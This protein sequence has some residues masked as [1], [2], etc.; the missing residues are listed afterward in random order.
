MHNAH[1][2]RRVFYLSKEGFQYSV[3]AEIDF[4]VSSSNWQRDGNGHPHEQT[5]D[6]ILDVF[7]RRNSK[8]ERSRHMGVNLQVKFL[9]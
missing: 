2:Y 1:Q 7:I 9:V 3:Q 5:A 6:S 4:V 8:P